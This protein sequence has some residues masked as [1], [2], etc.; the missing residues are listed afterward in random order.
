MISCSEGKK[1]QVSACNISLTTEN[2]SKIDYNENLNVDIFINK[3]NRLIFSYYNS[4]DKNIYLIP[5]KLI[6]EILE[7]KRVDTD[8]NVII[9]P[10]IK[11]IVIDKIYTSFIDNSKKKRI[12]DVDSTMQRNYISKIV[13]LAP[14]EIYMKEFELN[15]NKSDS[16][17]Y[18]ILFFEKG[19][20]DDS[21]II[22]I[23]YPEN[24]IVS[25]IK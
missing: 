13:E 18:K 9:K 19:S 10:Y 24:M 11:Q 2:I 6:F 17:R 20:V 1:E 23:K 3:G 16:G 5:P 14:K 4:S 25:I 22:K 21:K 12:I 15:C 7:E 8:K